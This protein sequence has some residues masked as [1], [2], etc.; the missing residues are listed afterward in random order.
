MACSRN[1]IAVCKALYQSWKSVPIF[2]GLQYY[3]EL[4]VPPNTNYRLFL[5]GVAALNVALCVIVEDVFMEYVIF[6]GLR[7]Q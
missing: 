4:F 6:R 5:L 1:L 2:S 3:F 7:K